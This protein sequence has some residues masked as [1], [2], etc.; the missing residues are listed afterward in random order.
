VGAEVLESELVGYD[1]I[2]L[3]EGLICLRGHENLLDRSLERK[4]S[5]ARLRDTYLSIAREYA[6][7]LASLCPFVRTIALCGSLATGGFSEEDDIDLNIITEDGCRY[8]TYLMANLLGLKYSIRLRKKPVDRL[9]RMPL[10]PKVICVN[11][12]VEES[13]TRPFSRQDEQMAFEL[14][15]SRPLY[16][17]GYFREMLL[18]NRWLSSFFPQ[19][20]RESEE[21]SEVSTRGTLLA[22]LLRTVCSLRPMRGLLERLSKMISW[23]FYKFVHWTRRRDPEARERIEFI[24]RVKEPYE[25][26]QD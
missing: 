6:A 26:F 7:E 5:N 4:R 16:G 14:L 1:E 25:V 10:V 20:Y 19:A 8:I 21:L 24:K 9:H 18:S 3:E 15:V 23:A 22:S 12:I 11:V 13:W 17:A 2:R